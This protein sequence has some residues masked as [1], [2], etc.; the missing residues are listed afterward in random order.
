MAKNKTKKTVLQN[1]SLTSEVTVV[2]LATLTSTVLGLSGPVSHTAQLVAL[3]ERSIGNALEHV[4]A[5]G[6]G[7]PGILSRQS[8]DE[9]RDRNRSHYQKMYAPTTQR[10]NGRLWIMSVG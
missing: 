3:G 8:G 6:G 5:R 9:V 4:V 10:T 1:R 7:T 2:L